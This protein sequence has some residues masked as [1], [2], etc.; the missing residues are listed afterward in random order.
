MPLFVLS[1]LTLIVLA[2]L[3]VALP[4]REMSDLENRVLTQSPPRFLSDRFSESFERFAADQLPGRDRF[5]ALHAMTEQLQLKLS[6]SGVIIMPPDRLLLTTDGYRDDYVR[7]N[8]R[9]LK[10]IADGTGKRVLLLAVPTAAYTLVAGPIRPGMPLKDEGALIKAAAGEIET[11]IPKYPPKGASEPECYY[12][13]DHH[14]TLHGAYCGYLAAAEALGLVPG[15]PESAHIHEADGFY[16]SL[17]ARLPSPLIGADT[18]TWY[19]DGSLTLFIGENKADG[20]V[21][22]TKLEG[23]DKYAALFYGNHPMITLVNDRASSGTLFVIKDSYANALL[24]LL[25]RHYRRVIAVDPRYYPG[26]I[27]EKVNASEGDTVLCVYGMNTLATGR[28]IELME[29]L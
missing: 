8:A 11:V 13:T 23:R 24:P 5:V 21:D 25:A 9:A 1:F 7:R 3:S 15:E 20:T 27:I 4:S 19:D 22:T 6:S 14:W 16:G 2:V 12:R 10:D 29:G 18:L 26:N 28:T 17:Y